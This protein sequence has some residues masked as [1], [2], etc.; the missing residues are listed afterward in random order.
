MFCKYYR[1]NILVYPHLEKYY[2]TQPLHTTKMSWVKSVPGAAGR[3]AL[4]ISRVQKAEADFTS[5]CMRR[6]IGTFL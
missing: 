1:N 6:P 3:R 5:D 4:R 2:G